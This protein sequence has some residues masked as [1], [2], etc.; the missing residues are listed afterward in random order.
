MEM[1]GTPLF[2]A[3]ELLRRE[4]YDEKVD[5]WSFACVL[6]SMW[7]HEQPYSTRDT[8]RD[9]IALVANEQLQPAV[10]GFLGD[11]VRRCAVFDPALRCRFAEV[12]EALS[13]PELHGA[14]ILLAPGP[15]SPEQRGS[16]L[17]ALPS[18]AL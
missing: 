6:E 13:N 18:H 1:A 2:C 3:P 11:V 10:D 8:D 14:A 12:V 16:L 17:L 9:P 4:R 7:T 5:V 15:P